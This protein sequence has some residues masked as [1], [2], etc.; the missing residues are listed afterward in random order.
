MPIPSS[1]LDRSTRLLG[2]NTKSN[3]A[4]LAWLPRGRQA[5]SRERPGHGKV[6]DRASMAAEAMAPRS[7]NRLSFRRKPESMSARHCRVPLDAGF[8]RNDGSA[9]E[10]L[11]TAIPSL[12]DFAVALGMGASGF[13]G[14]S[15]RRR[16][17]Q[18]HADDGPRSRGPVRLSPPPGRCRR[19]FAR[20]A[21]DQCR[22]VLRSKYSTRTRAQRR[23]SMRVMRRDTM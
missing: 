2:V 13:L 9:T 4:F 14:P 22:T 8:R 7:D 10:V 21:A 5:K 20:D 11:S 15:E 1:S 16:G 3:H 6:S 19:S 18:R 12:D 23:H 17:A